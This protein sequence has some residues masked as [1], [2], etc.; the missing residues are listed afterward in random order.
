MV[1]CLSIKN[2]TLNEAV[3]SIT[4]SE[5]I[6][7]IQ[8]DQPS[9]IPWIIRLLE[10]PSSPIALPGKIS[11]PNHDCLHVILGRGVT[12]ED[13]AFI[14][15]FTMGSDVKTNWFHLAIFKFFSRFIYPQK[16]QFNREHLKIFDL[17]VAYGR[18]PGIIKNI[19]QIDFKL[20]HNKKIAELRKLFGISLDELRQLRKFENWLIN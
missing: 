2:L 15:G 4:V 14:I 20:Y 17:G 19:N 18:K 5:V 9:D 16:Y 7:S 3:K 11:L 10:N 8:I 12:L 13:E 1:A 6:K